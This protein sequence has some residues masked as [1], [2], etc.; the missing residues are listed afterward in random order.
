MRDL[1][2]DVISCYIWR[3]DMVKIDVFD[4]II[5]EIQKKGENL[6]IKAIFTQICI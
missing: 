5:I 2:C 3:F 1:I 6:E 4:K